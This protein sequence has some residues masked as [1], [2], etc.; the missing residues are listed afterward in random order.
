M[1]RSDKVGAWLLKRRA[2]I[3]LNSATEEQ[4]AEFLAQLR[5]DVKDFYRPTEKKPLVTYIEE[6]HYSI[7]PREYGALIAAFMMRSFGPAIEMM[8]IDFSSMEPRILD[9]T[10]VETL[11][12][13]EQVFKRLYGGMIWW[14]ELE[15]FS[16]YDESH[17]IKPTKM[18]AGKNPFS[19]S[20]ISKYKK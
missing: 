3:D 11:E 14:N 2:T 7:A 12:K 18:G 19:V 4:V 8:E 13:K 15:S 17:H 20:H 1:R 16:Y 6:D 10:M 5:Q 9:K